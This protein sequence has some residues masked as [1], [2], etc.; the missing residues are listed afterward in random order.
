MYVLR[1][2]LSTVRL[3]QSD[4]RNNNIKENDINQTK[5]NIKKN[6]SMTTNKENKII[7]KKE[8]EN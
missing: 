4:I 7:I 1:N 8:Y 5:R 2:L 6:K 3:Q